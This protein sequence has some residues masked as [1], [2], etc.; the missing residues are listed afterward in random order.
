MSARFVESG[1]LAL[2][3]IVGTSCTRHEPA[4]IVLR[5]G[6]VYPFAVD[7][8]RAEAVALKNG[9]IVYV[10]DDRGAGRWVGSQTAVIELEG[11]MVLPG[12]HDT[13]MHPRGGI[14]LAE[15][16]LDELR[17][18]QA[19]VDSVR[20]YAE[21][22][23]DL[24]WVRGR[25]WQLPVFPDANP[26]KEWLDAIVPD[27]PVYLVAAD[28]HSTWVNSKALHLAG[29]TRDTKDPV[30]GRI[31][32][33]PRTGEPSGTLR[34][35]AQSLVGI[36]LPAYTQEETRTGLR[37]ALNLANRYGITS[38][39]E[40][41]AHPDLLEAYAALDSTGE[42]TARVVAAIHVDPTAGPAQVDSLRAL[43]GRFTGPRYFAPRAAKIFVDGVIEAKTAAL[44]APYRDGSGRQGEPN[45]SPRAL[46]SLVAALDV[47]GF[48]V[49]VHA[50]GD[51]AV[52]MALD[53]FEF[54]RRHNGPRDAR[55]I[56]A[57]LELIDSTDIPRFAALGV[58]PSFQPLW[59]YADDYITLLTEPVLG[60][61]R[62][63]WLYPIGSVARSGAHLAA[64]SDWSVSSM[65]PL[66]AIQ[67]AV[68]RRAPTAGPGAAWLP[69]ETVSLATIL[70]A[71]TAGGAY[72]AGDEASNGTLEVGKAADLIVVNRDLYHLAPAEIHTAR[73]LLTLLD[74][75]I[76]FRD[77]VLRRSGGSLAQRGRSP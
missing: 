14:G 50:I 76:V 1:I 49:H 33:D 70:R 22:H 26:R 24:P 75:R 9:R 25:G 71:Y 46:D 67:V 43:R 32:R 40:A 37:R 4:D 60:P 6:V 58:I 62:S 56:V 41:D 15:C 3:L 27:R 52:R 34:E 55:P 63:R 2:L 21:A 23:P 66:E 8:A 48:Q 74:G 28:G 45:L 72:A 53:A 57:H 13:H 77:P 69:Q 38:L 35:S 68:T 36:H 51:R 39:H 30:N 12:F 73:V 42:L 7:S 29:I 54:A 47:A 11:R 44:L 64:G 61:E 20:R 18:S 59:A 17:T 31:E 65:D 19:I 10:G 16:T 5:H